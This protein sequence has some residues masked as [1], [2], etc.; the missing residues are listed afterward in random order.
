MKKKWLIVLM[1]SVLLLTLLLPIAS[2]QPEVAASDLFS[3]EVRAEVN[4]EKISCWKSDGGE[5]YLFLPTYAEL[6]TAVFRLH[7]D[8]EVFLNGE[9]LTDGKTLA[10][11]ELNKKYSLSFTHYGEKQTADFTIMQSKNI[12]SMYIETESGNMEYIHTN[13]GKGEKGSLSAYT[14]DGK[15]NCDVK[16]A[17]I[18]GRGNNTWDVLDK[19][20][21]SLDLSEAVDL[22][23]M[24]KADRWI[25]LANA[26]DGSNLR[27]KIA[28]DFAKE[29]GLSYSPDSRFVDLYLNGEYAGLYLLCE[30]NEINENRVDISAE[31]GV[32]LSWEDE[33]HLKE[34]Q[35]TYITTAAG[36]AYRVHYPKSLD[37]NVLDEITKRCQAL[38]NAILNDS[39]ELVK[40]ID[41]ESWVRKYLVDEMLGN[42]D[43]YLISHYLYYENQSGKIF[44]G[45]VWDYDK[46]MGSTADEGWSITD[47]EVFMVDRYKDFAL[48]MGYISALL[49]KIEFKDLAK[50]LYIDEFTGGIND[51][52]HVKIPQYIKETNAS[53]EMNKTRWFSNTD[54]GSLEQEADKICDYITKHND[55]LKGAWIDG[56]EYCKVSIVKVPNDTFFTVPVG[57]TLIEMPKIENTDWGVLEGLYYS[58]TD[59]PFDITKPITEDIQLYAKW[60]DSASNKLDDIIKLA[61]FGVFCLV[62]AVMFFITLRQ[63][64]KSR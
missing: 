15:L 44:A 36:K 40:I 11:L 20:P 56:R 62:L 8:G 41:L 22:F 47:P 16:I 33:V 3:V 61:P 52:L 19:K 23:G 38:E 30:R 46:A 12:A 21:Y 60:N 29:M 27:N 7:T 26:A 57:G 43:G 50:Q 5:F 28:Y 4:S 35:R 55:F 1:A 13:K 10:D 17:S 64:K 49:S 48:D 25:L 2:A 34:K 42:L 18:S 14:S 24:G 32:L 37:E 53:F 45:P 51:F 6:S 39:G 58:D 59:E 9:K 31:N 63:I 54:L